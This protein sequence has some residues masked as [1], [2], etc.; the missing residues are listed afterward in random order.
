MT[1]LKSF[2]IIPNQAMGK[3]D[4][5][6]VAVICAWT[7][8]TGNVTAMNPSLQ[9]LE[10]NN[11]TIAHLQIQM[12]TIKRSFLHEIRRSEEN[13]NNLHWKLTITDGSNDEIISIFTKEHRLPQHF[14]NT[15][16]GSMD[17]RVKVIYNKNILYYLNVYKETVSLQA[18]DNG[19]Q[20]FVVY[21]QRSTSMLMQ[22][23]SVVCSQY[24]N[25]HTNTVTII[26][27]KALM[28]YICFSV[29]VMALLIL[30][31]INRKLR[32]C[33]TVAGSNTENLSIA[34]IASNVMFMTGSFATSIESLC[35]TIGVLL[36]YLWLSVFSF[37]SITVLFIGHNLMKMENI[38]ISDKKT[39]SNRRTLTGVGLLVPLIFVCPTICLDQYS[40]PNFSAGYGKE[41]CF[42]NQFPANLI[43]FSGPVIVSL[44]A[45]F[46]CLTIV[47]GKVCRLRIENAHLIK[48][49]LFQE[50]KIFFRFVIV[51]GMF[52]VAIVLATILESDSADYIFI[53]S[54]GL[55]GFFIAIANL[56]SRQMINK[57]KSV[58]SHSST[59]VTRSSKTR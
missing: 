53:L 58:S 31:I 5:I 37:M 8:E 19:C 55:H 12:T 32:L 15:S 3:D 34:L 40:V 33:F 59:N 43:F 27:V 30:I 48:S 20:S 22:V 2:Y 29:S 28:T 39:R 46:V 24:Y 57:I 16:M 26:S 45:N 41:V 44:F 49:P 38:N 50:A 52:W 36:H 17:S 23:E 25:D 1:T 42:P 11:A 14:K 51:S 18:I 47:I 9:I 10:M 35:Y 56:T 21:V 54:C 13:I 4:L 7:L 6:T